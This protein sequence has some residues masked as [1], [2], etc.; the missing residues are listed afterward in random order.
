[1]CSVHASRGPLEPAAT[2]LRSE[3]AIVCRLAEATLG[4]RT[5]RCRGPTFRADYTEHPR[6]DRAR[7][8]RLRAYD[9]KVEPARAASCCRTR[10]ATTGRSR[11]TTGQGDLHRQPAR[12]ARTCPRAGCCCRRCAATT[13]STPRSTASTTATAASRT[14]AASCSCTPT[15]SPRSASPT[16]TSSTWSASG[17]DGTERS[18]PGVPD[19][20]LRHPARLRR[21]LLPR[22]QPAGAAGLHRRGQQL[23]HLEVGRDPAGAGVRGPPGEVHGQ[24]RARRVGP[25]PQVGRAAGAAEL[26]RPAS[27]ARVAILRACS[28]TSSR[29]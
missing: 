23:P 8:A 18:V 11:P 19:R 24:G 12:R 26:I 14:A 5:A 20:R 1:M 6:R 29:A 7:R 2:H 10:R 17:S 21:G 22:D 9:E 28:P 25:R 16:A 4:D 27:T 15:T 3:V 13:S